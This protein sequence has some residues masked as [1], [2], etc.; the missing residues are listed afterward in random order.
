VHEPLPQV[1]V[2]EAGLGLVDPPETL[3]LVA[4][5]T[6]SRLGEPQAEHFIATS[7]LLDL[8]SISI[9]LPHFKHL[10]S[11]MGMGV[12][13]VCLNCTYVYYH[14]AVLVKSGVGIKR[15]EST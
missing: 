1:R 14:Q 9:S 12:S 4:L 13:P 11:Y 10:N 6:R 3:K 2:W 8:N 15:Q 5:I 7:S